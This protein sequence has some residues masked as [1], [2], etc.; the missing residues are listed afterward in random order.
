M[1]MDYI[2]LDTNPKR[3]DQRFDVLLTLSAA[4]E[5]FRRGQSASEQTRGHGEREATVKP[6]TKEPQVN[7]GIKP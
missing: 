2:K 1:A 5:G 3:R 6:D 4:Q 7:E